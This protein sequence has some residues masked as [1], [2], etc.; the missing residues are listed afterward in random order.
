M[1]KTIYL[2]FII[3][4]AAIYFLSMSEKVA[5]VPVYPDI[6]IDMTEDVGTPMVYRYKTI[7]RKVDK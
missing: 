3:I 5:V 4:I 7:K 6:A 2:F 1:I